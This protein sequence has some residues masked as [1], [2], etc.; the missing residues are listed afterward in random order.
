MFYAFSG[1]LEDGSSRRPVNN[2]S[3][4][5]MNDFGFGGGFFG[6]L[7]RHMVVNSLLVV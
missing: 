5:L 6:G 1:M 3:L 4:S 7:M 2:N